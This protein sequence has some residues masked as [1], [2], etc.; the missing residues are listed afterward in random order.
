MTCVCLLFFTISAA[1]GMTLIIV[2][3]DITTPLRD[4]LFNKAYD[5]V[6]E[7]TDP[8]AQTQMPD[9]VANYPPATKRV[10]KS[11]FWERVY[12]L[13]NC[14][15]CTGFWCGLLWGLFLVCQLPEQTISDV[16]I[17]VTAHGFT[18]SLYAMLFD[19]YMTRLFTGR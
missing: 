12:T 1:A 16:I 3:G 2:R 14:P 11:K 5:V 9:T 4:C 13:I 17:K 7:Y 19:L 10:I 6:T 18:V 15:Q 8:S